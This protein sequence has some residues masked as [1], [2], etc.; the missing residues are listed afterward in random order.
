M[1]MTTGSWSEG[2]GA[3]RARTPCGDLPDIKEVRTDGPRYDPRPP[4]GDRSAP[5]HVGDNSRTVVRPQRSVVHLDVA[6]QVV[7]GPSLEFD[8]DRA[9]V[10]LGSRTVRCRLRGAVRRLGQLGAISHVVRERQ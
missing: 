5:V 3:S 10:D 7:A 8:K 6:A 1:A 4:K 9:R 2:V